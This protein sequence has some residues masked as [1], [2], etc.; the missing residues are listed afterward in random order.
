MTYWFTAGAVGVLVAIELFYLVRLTRRMRGLAATEDRIARFGE[1]LTLL[2]ETCETGFRTM[3]TEIGRMA[4]AAPRRA[5]R[6]VATDRLTRAARRGDA[7]HQMAAAE[8]L[9]E[10]EVRLRLLLADPRPARAPEGGR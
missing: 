8:R 6:R 5:R 1:A 7:I 10:G 4:E 9:S 3:G 2:T